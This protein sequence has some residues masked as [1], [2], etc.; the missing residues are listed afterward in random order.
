MPTPTPMPVPGP[1][2][3][4]VYGP[5]AARVKRA[6][7]ASGGPLFL[8][9]PTATGKTTLAIQAAEALGMGVEVVVFDPGMDA[10]ELFGG[11]ARRTASP[12]ETV[13]PAETTVDGAPVN[14][15][16]MLTPGRLPAWA[17]AGRGDA[18]DPGGHSPTTRQGAAPAR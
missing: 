2:L 8:S 1:T 13:S 16:T 15:T 12:A 6:L 3:R 11:Y 5:H 18:G 9:G 4:K 14:I 10:Q 7:S 17:R